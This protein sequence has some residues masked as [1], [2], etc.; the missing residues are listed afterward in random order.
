MLLN[1]GLGYCAVFPMALV[2]VAVVAPEEADEMGGLAPYLIFVSLLL[3]LFAAVFWVVNHLVA[4]VGRI[5]GRAFWWTA[6]AVLLVPTL[7]AMLRWDLWREI[8]L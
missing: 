7:F 3:L 2:A 8:A 6:V 4:A 1:L 5:G